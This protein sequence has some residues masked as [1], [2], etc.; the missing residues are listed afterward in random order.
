MTICV[1]LTKKAGWEI[2]FLLILFLAL[3]T[4]LRADSDRLSYDPAIHAVDTGLLCAQADQP[5]IS[6]HPGS[7]MK[8]A[9]ICP[10]EL[11]AGLWAQGFPMQFRCRALGSEPIVD[12][13]S[14]FRLGYRNYLARPSGF[15]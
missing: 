4:S 1:R 7:H 15:Q 12:K 6:Y 9:P 5:F 3:V 10:N 14:N 11:G 2:G 8:S 13:S